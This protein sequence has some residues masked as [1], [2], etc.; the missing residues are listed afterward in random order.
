MDEFD[1]FLDAAPGQ[2]VAVDG[3]EGERIGGSLVSVDV[4]TR[5]VEI[6]SNGGLVAVAFPPEVNE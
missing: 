3:P 4:A 6:A 5:T 2:Y 1:K